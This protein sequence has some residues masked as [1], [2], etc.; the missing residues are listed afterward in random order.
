MKRELFRVKKSRYTNW[1]EVFKNPG[2]ISV[3]SFV[4]GH[5][6]INKRGALNP[7]HPNAGNIEEELL[8][9][10]I[11]SH[12]I[13]H[14][15]FGDYLVDA[16][17]DSSYTEDPQGKMNGLFA[18]LFKKFK[19]ASDEY[20]QEKNQNISY[21]LKSNSINLNGVFLSHLHSDHI[22][23]VRELPKDIPY[24]VGKGERYVQHKPLFYGDYLKGIL[25]LY[26]IDFSKASIM[27]VL[28]PCVDIFSDGSFWA[29]PTPGHTKGH[30]SFL[31]NG[32]SGP[33]LL[34]TDA[35]FIKLGFEKG[36]GSSDYTDDVLMAQ[37][38]LNNL[39][40]FKKVYPNVEVLC[41]HEI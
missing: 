34:A 27:P 32:Q 1:D 11:I 16:G 40:E 41:G 12:W 6:M 18:G 5:V 4:T 25:V 30:I 19:I 38:S 17:L 8:K 37:S 35:C 33:I 28:G 31:I 21:H 22:A 3:K 20:L 24:V 13:H 29:I 39:V 14:D 23:G 9:V 26:E 36:V 2:P 7:E 15:E 10:P